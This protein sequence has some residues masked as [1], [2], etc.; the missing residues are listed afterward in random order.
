MPKI[1][2]LWETR[3][4][5]LESEMNKFW[6]LEP[7]L[8]EEDKTSNTT[9]WYGWGEQEISD[10]SDELHTG[11]AWIVR[12]LWCDI[13]GHSSSN[14]PPVFVTKSPF[15]IFG[16]NI[17]I[18]QS[19]QTGDIRISE[20]S[21]I[22]KLCHNES[23]KTAFHKFQPRVIHAYFWH[24]RQNEDIIRTFLHNNQLPGPLFWGLA[25]PPEG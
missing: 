22:H 3:T 16:S 25:L 8:A 13:T 9:L 14:Q 15:F 17:S 20:H 24:N 12:H 6:A 2:R 11:G 18:C 21:L 23:S 7:F 1:K 19:N 10:C 5:D 4:A